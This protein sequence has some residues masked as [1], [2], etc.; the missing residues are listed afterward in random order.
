VGTLERRAREREETRTMILDAA[1]E[2]FVERGVEAVTMR[3]IAQRIEY[4]PTAIYHHFRDKHALLVELCVMDF[5]R[6]GHVFQRLERVADPVERLRRFGL[7]YAEFGLTNPSHYRFM[8][9]TERP[10]LDE[11]AAHDRLHPEEDAYTMLRATCA[12]AVAGGRLRPEWDDPEAL[13][14][15]LWSAV[16]GAVSLRITKK[17]EAWID[18]RDAAR[19][20]RATVET[21]VR[22]IVRDPD[23]LPSL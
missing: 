6:L 4:T 16:H 22:G 5:Q 1:R 3:A 12:Q 17:G 13:A 19:T 10:A 21:M 11:A 20:A 14:Q 18:W 7:A 8:F 2:L 23:A 9:M 15:M